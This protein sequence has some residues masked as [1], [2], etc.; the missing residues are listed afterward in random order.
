MK[1]LESKEN[2]YMTINKNNFDKKESNNK[3]LRISFKIRTM[4]N[5]NL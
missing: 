2:S 3:P 1:S 5:L 4:V